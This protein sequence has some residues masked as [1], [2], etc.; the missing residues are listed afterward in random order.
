MIESFDDMNVRFKPDWQGWKMFHLDRFGKEMIIG[1]LTAAGAV[2][3]IGRIA[4]L[5]KLKVTI[6]EEG[7]S[8]KEKQ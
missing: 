1:K 3:L 8:G 4:V 6:E 7:T 2:R 5:F